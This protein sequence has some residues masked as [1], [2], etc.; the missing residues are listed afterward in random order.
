MAFLK[1]VFR[2]SIILSYGLIALEIIIMVTPFAF[3]FY[4]IYGP[5]LKGLYAFPPTRWLTAFILSYILFSGDPMLNWAERIGFYLFPIGLWIFIIGAVHVYGA[6]LFR[7]GPVT[8]GLYTFVRH[9]QYLGLIVSGLGL[10]LFWPRFFI[11][12]M[13]V[14]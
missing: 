6:K 7:K 2:G 13:Y 12:V 10:F 8:N 5:F 1:K 4:S 3:Y 11:L 9:P 14:T